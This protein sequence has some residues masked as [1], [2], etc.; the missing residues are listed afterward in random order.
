[1]HYLSVGAATETGGTGVHDPDSELHGRED[2]GQRL[3]VRVVAVHYA[4][5]KH[6]DFRLD[7]CSSVAEP[8]SVMSAPAHRKI[9]ACDE[10]KN[11]CFQAS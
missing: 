2:V 6:F 11:M 7:F 10:N 9:L 5:Y 4:L 8:V 1:M 3:A